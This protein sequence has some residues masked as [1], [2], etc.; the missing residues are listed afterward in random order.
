MSN[1]SRQPR[2]AHQVVILALPEVV[3]FDLSTA[4][5]IFGFRDEDEYQATVV[6][7]APG[8]VSTSTG[9][10][11]GGVVGPEAILQ[12]DTVIVPGFNSRLDVTDPAT[13]RVLDLLRYAVEDGVRVVSICTGAF[14][15]A[16]AG[17]LDGRSATTHWC[18]TEELRCR[19]PAVSV[20]PG[21][22]YIDH[23]DIATSAGVAAGIDLCLHL[24]RRD[25]GEDVAAR[26]ARRMVVAPHRTGG[27][28]Q[29]IEHPTPKPGVGMSPVVQWMTEHMAEPL[30]V[31]ECADRAGMSLRHFQRRFTAEFGEPPAAWLNRQRVT[32]ARRLLE[33]SDLTVDAIA[34]RTGLGTATNMRRHVLGQVGVTPTAYRRSFRRTP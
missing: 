28:A 17:L 15:L 24:V 25:M 1:N 30:T 14:A 23:G 13:G 10:T 6:G 29:F 9:F 21:V 4:A 26:I 7:A 3:A 2:C 31:A 18:R 16:A 19:Y 12:A 32:E 11:V 34:R 20:H 27:Q 22:L 33:V 8:D 5:Q